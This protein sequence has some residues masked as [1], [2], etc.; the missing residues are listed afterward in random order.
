MKLFTRKIL[1][2][3]LLSCLLVSVQ[4]QV[5]KINS[6]TPTSGSIGAQITLS[7]SNFNTT[8]VNNSVYFG[9]V[10][11]NIVSAT[12]T[13]L[14][15]TV[16]TGA[17][18]GPL[19]V[20]NAANNLSCYSNAYFTPIFSP[21]VTTLT[22]SDFSSRSDFTVNTN[23]NATL[24]ADVDDDGK[25]DIVVANAGSNNISVFL[26]TSSFGSISFATKVDFA[27]GN[28]PLAL[29]A[30]DIDGDGKI[31]IITTNSTANTISVMRNTSVTGTASFAAKVDFSTAT[32]PGSVSV[33][34]IDGDGKLDVAVANRGSASVSVFRNTST[35]G[36]INFATKVDFSTAT[37]P[38]SIATGDID[39]DGNIDIAVANRNSASVSVLRNTSTTGVISFATKA[40]FTT[41]SDPASVSIG[42]LDGDGKL[43]I[44]TQNWNPG[45]ASALRNTS[46]TGSIT[47]ASKYDF[48]LNGSGYSM[49]LAD[50]TG[51]GKVDAAATHTTTNAVGIFINNSTPGNLSLSGVTNL[52]TGHVCC[53][54]RWRWKTRLDFSKLLKQFL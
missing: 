23:P 22:T 7:G 26:N 43:D 36:V 4:A 17:N 2:F 14:V 16:P 40:D 24:A 10:K 49:V 29:F 25:L 19:K 48:W 34:D 53:R 12:T 21:S 42:D 52:S 41:N 33:A 50:F 31:D 13:S 18:Y 3:S 6:F 5:P 1:V 27:T 44:V 45:N 28:S 39:G 47:F 11:A 37:N 20:T 30:A 9:S 46:T 8:A 51:D 32:T 15:V 38:Y 35:T 54:F